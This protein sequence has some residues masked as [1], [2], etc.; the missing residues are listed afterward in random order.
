MEIRQFRRQYD[1]ELIPASHHGIILG[2]LVWDPIIGKPKFNHPGMSNHIFNAFRTANLINNEELV[3]F[4]ES[5]KNIPL[6]PAQFSSIV[7]EVEIDIDFAG[8]LDYHQINAL[9]ASMGL[10]K[11]KKFSFADLQAR[12]MTNLERVRIFDLLDTLKK[13]QWEEY[14]GKIR[15]LFMIT[16]LYYGNI[17]MIIDSSLKTTFEAQSAMKTIDAENQVSLGNRLEYTFAHNEVPFAMR[18]ERVKRFIA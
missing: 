7:S 10:E 2:S 15:R 11:I 4:L 6:G 1:L 8:S 16:E 13:D 14:D 3:S 5:S 12:I 9:E 17:K 18:L